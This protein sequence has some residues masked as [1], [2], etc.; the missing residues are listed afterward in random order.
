LQKRHFANFLKDSRKA[1]V[2]FTSIQSLLQN[3]LMK[4]QPLRICAFTAFAVLLLAYGSGLWPHKALAQDSAVGPIDQLVELG[5]TAAFSVDAVSG[6]SYQWLRNGVPIAGQTSSVLTLE[7][8]QIEDAGFYSCNLSTNDT[9]T[10]SPA[11]SLMVYTL[12]P[13]GFIVVY[14][15]PIVGSGGS[16][17]C[18]GPYIGYV[19]YTKTVQQGWGW[20]PETNTT[21]FT[22]SDTT[23]TNTKVEY[24][25]NYGDSGCN[26]TSVTIPNPPASTLYRFAIYFTNNVPTTNYPITLVGF[27]P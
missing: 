27:N 12:S 22:A 9:A 7:N 18:P 1:R 6:A 23:R 24:G 19:T 14:A 26:K 5:G 10:A 16:G 8:L 2:S 13:D 4:K 3:H 20:T 15:A 17:T 21:V 25:G 11:A